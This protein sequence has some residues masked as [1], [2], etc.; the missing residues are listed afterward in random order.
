MEWGWPS[1]RRKLAGPHKS[2]NLNSAFQS[3]RAQL[4][5]PRRELHQNPN[6]RKI[7]PKVPSS[8]NTVTLKV[9]QSSASH[10]KFRL[11]LNEPSKIHWDRI[12]N[13]TILGSGAF[14]ECFSHGAS[15][16]RNGLMEWVGLQR[17]YLCCQSERSPPTPHDAFHHVMMQQDGSRDTA[18]NLGLH[19]L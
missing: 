8:S 5:L 16:L 18:L 17:E 11:S 7:L 2:S 15:T 12:A 19:S 14:E 3:T 10:M 6:E 9:L 13:V 4:K 1:D